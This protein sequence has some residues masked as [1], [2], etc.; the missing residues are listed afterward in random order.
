METDSH[1]SSLP[2]VA[3]HSGGTFKYKKGSCLFVGR[4][5]EF[6]KPE[7]KGGVVVSCYEYH[8]KEARIQ[9]VLL[10]KT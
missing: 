9:E 6:Q 10:M 2:D 7:K 8:K 1:S 3:G 5:L 4:R